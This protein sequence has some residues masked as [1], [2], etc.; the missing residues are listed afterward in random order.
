MTMTSTLTYN[1]RD[2]GITRVAKHPARYSRGMLKIFASYL[3][4]GWRVLDPLAGT[5]K[6]GRLKHFGK[7]ITVVCNELEPE[8]A[9]EDS[10]DEWHYGDAAHMD[11]AIDGE[12]DALVFSPV[13]GNRMSDTYTDHTKRI[14]YRAGLGRPL[15]PENTGQ[16]QW[17][18]K[19]RVKHLAIYNEC[20]RVL[21]AG[22]L[23]LCNVS[24]HIRD[25]VEVPVAPWHLA[26]L[27]ELG[28]ALVQ[29]HEIETPRVRLGKNYDKRV[30]CEYIFV[31]RKGG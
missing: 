3:Q 12:F 10:V 19:Y 16:L 21:R 11:W 31:L 22:G 2:E 8:W 5:G 20:V 26:C 23:M 24:N 6:A 14:T 9:L 1:T 25:G 28:L 30:G 27:R 18:E 15:H 7:E 13:Y 4:D 29:T 17:G